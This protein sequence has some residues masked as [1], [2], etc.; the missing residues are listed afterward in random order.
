MAC[1]QQNIFGNEKNKL[2]LQIRRKKKTRKRLRRREFSEVIRHKC[3]VQSAVCLILS[4]RE[5]WGVVK[6][7]QPVFR[8]DK[9]L[10][11]W[12]MVRDRG[13]RIAQLRRDNAIEISFRE[14]IARGQLHLLFVDNPTVTA[15]LRRRTGTT[16]KALLEKKMYVMW[17]S[18]RG[19][20]DSV[21]VFP[22]K[23]RKKETLVGNSMT[24]SIDQNYCGSV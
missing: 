2:S 13:I 10:Y 8:Y 4:D 1:A 15:W 23:L 20:L 14:N 16:D 18:D 22:G 19:E 12:G 21:F 3:S 24:F 6:E 5:Q 11:Q 7:K 9:A 17:S